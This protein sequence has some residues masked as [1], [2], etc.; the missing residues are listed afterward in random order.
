MIA[1]VSH[2]NLALNSSAPTARLESTNSTFQYVEAVG[3]EYT[4][5]GPAQRVAD[6][7]DDWFSWLRSRDVRRVN[8]RT[9]RGTGPLP[10]HVAVAFAGAGPW[11][12]TYDYGSGSEYWRG[13]WQIG[14][15]G[16][17]TPWRVTYLGQ[18]SKARWTFRE[19]ALD[20]ARDD[21]SSALADSHEVAVAIGEPHWA[22]WFAQATEQLTA[23]NPTARFHADA[24]PPGY[25]LAAR[26]LFGAAVGSWVFGGMG[27]WN[28]ISVSDPSLRKRYDDI[29]TRLFA[30]M[31]QAFESVLDSWQP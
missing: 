1:L 25:S 5:G 19:V 14:A 29:S 7:A 31:L 3:Y 16:S 8:L 6:N 30:E 24:L 12:I 22:E 2:A 27:S 9:L 10:G 18:P 23:P 26:Q 4:T 20:K 21:L 17:R 13:I 28:D 15:S 11:V